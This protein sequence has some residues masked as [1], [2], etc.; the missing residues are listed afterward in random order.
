MIKTMVTSTF[1]ALC[2][3]AGAA[4]AESV[5]AAWAQVMGSDG[6][7]T[8]A[9]GE[10]PLNLSLRFI[11]DQQS[12]PSYK[13]RA[14]KADGSQQT[15][16][17]AWIMRSNRPASQFDEV[18]VCQTNMDEDWV[19]A[20]LLDNAGQPVT[21]PDGTAVTLAGANR[22]TGA[23]PRVVVFGDTGCRGLILNSG[24]GSR[25]KQDCAKIG[26]IKQL[27][28]ETRFFFAEIAALAMQKNPDIAI[29][30][31][32]YRYDQESIRDWDN[33]NSDFFSRTANGPLMQV[34]WAFV[35]GNH[36]T[37]DRAGHGWYFF[38]G[39]NDSS[40]TCSGMDRR[41]VTSWYF[42][43]RDTSLAPTAPHR[44]VIVG[45]GPSVSRKTLPDTLDCTAIT[46]KTGFLSDQELWEQAI[47]EFKTALGWTQDKTTKGLP[48]H[49]TFVM[50]RPIWGL[51]TSGFHPK[52]V[53][54]H[55]GEA[56]A[57]A[58]AQGVAPEC[59]GYNDT[60]KI[61]ACGLRS[62][63]AA[64][65][66]MFTNVVFRDNALPQQIVVGNS[67][68]KLDGPP[69]QYFNPSTGLSFRPCKVPDMDSRG[70]H[71]RRHDGYAMEYR[72][73]MPKT[74]GEDAF[75]FLLLTRNHLATSGWD[76]TA[77][78]QDGQSQSL[79]TAKDIASF[80]KLDDCH[81]P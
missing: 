11:T 12:C 72:G 51:D 29:H 44:F 59:Q 1:A 4:H 55:V 56:L 74:L 47:C 27:K 38:F 7:I 28:P 30:L 81:R 45:T 57:A 65:E 25:F 48:I 79:S 20:A 9:H 8:K 40:I 3:M 70:L 61:G 52:Q 63:L 2:T 54:R 53:D 32:D 42:E 21:S 37:C 24:S 23:A 68:V 77:F 67:G 36:E 22:A 19:A 49:T 39:P 46:K 71:H 17:P 31:G 62:V 6:P 80:G 43:M 66:H 26:T 5:H 34:P 10:M 75:G 73:R 14:Q 50:H 41:L 69:G 13:I 35:R 60:G 16:S 58:L 18:T 15:L 33:W 64:H 78:Y 76:G